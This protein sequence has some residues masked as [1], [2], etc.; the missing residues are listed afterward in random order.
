[1]A[2]VTVA[3][4]VAFS[5]PGRSL[6]SS[7]ILSAPP[8]PLSGKELRDFKAGKIKSNILA[9]PSVADEA[10]AKYRGKKN[11]KKAAKLGA[12]GEGVTAGGKGGKD[13]G[14]EDAAEE[15]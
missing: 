11:G 7:S 9:K 8:V 15:T 14:P 6:S 13:A 1:M 2:L 3:E 4:V 5:E 10:N 12:D